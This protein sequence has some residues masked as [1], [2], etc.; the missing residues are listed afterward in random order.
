MGAE[1]V[2][3]V[4]P[5]ERVLTCI[6]MPLIRIIKDW[7][8]LLIFLF[9]QALC[10]MVIYVIK[11]LLQFSEVSINPILGGSRSGFC[12]QLWYLH[13]ITY[14]FGMKIWGWRTSI[15]EGKLDAFTHLNIFFVF[16]SKARYNQLFIQL[17]ILV[18]FPPFCGC[19]QSNILGIG[20]C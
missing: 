20:S 9:I 17:S 2:D 12:T 18:F 7:N 11:Q 15:L 14:F 10:L 1:L 13:T 5:Y 3:L 4:T 6:L 16:L 8:R 19:F